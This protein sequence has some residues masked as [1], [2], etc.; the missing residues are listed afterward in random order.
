MKDVERREKQS[1]WWQSPVLLGIVHAMRCWDEL[2]WPERNAAQQQPVV[3][4]VVEDGVSVNSS[5]LGRGGLP[6]L[7]AAA[8]PRLHCSRTELQ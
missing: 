7:R 1:G 4:S 3:L 6:F 5:W 8:P 2:C